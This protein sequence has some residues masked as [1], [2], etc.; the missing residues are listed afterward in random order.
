M[1]IIGTLPNNIQNGQAEDATPVMANFNFIINQVN[2]A[3]AP[4]G[5]FT[6]PAGTRMLFNQAAPPAGWTQETG[7]AFNDTSVRTVTG[8]GGSTAGSVL[9]SSWNFSGT[10]NVNAFTLTLAQ[11][12]THTH[13]DAGHV[14]GLNDPAHAHTPNGGG[15]FLTTQNAGSYA[16]GVNNLAVIATTSAATTG[17]TMNSAQANIQ[18]AGS[19]AAVTPTYQTPQVKFSDYI[20][21]IKS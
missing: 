3:A 8:A 15:G 6:A 10:F 9:W 12:P 2:A 18:N 13:V 17:I 20:I 4:L 14:H 19:S 11:L 1:P 5:T 16:N 21:G 7:A